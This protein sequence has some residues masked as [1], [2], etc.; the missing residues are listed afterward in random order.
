[1]RG[2]CLLCES[3]N[4]RA[5]LAVLSRVAREKGRAGCALSRQTCRAC[6]AT[7]LTPRH[8]PPLASRPATTPGA[9]RGFSSARRQIPDRA[10]EDT[11]SGAT[12]WRVWPPPARNGSTGHSRGRR[13][14]RRKQRGH[15]GP[16]YLNW[17]RL[18]GGSAATRAFCDAKRPGK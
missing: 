13:L 3:I 17:M 14:M 12:A 11:R 15:T 4:L 8:G 1:M 10:A 18:R 6:R 5:R 7:S 9:L 2:A 16:R